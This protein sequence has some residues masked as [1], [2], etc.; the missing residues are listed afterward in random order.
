MAQP[1][2]VGISGGGR[3]GGQAKP[4]QACRGAASLASAPPTACPTPAAGT[5]HPVSH[6]RC[7]HSLGDDVT[8]I[9]LIKRH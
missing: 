5:F 1:G 6:S 2:L 4:A 7:H 9:T 8:L 3:L